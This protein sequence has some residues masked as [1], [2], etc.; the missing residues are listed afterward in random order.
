MRDAENNFLFDCYTTHT[1]IPADSL[2]TRCLTGIQGRNTWSRVLPSRNAL[3]SP[4]RGRRSKGATLLSWVNMRADRSSFRRAAIL[5]QSL[6]CLHA[7]R[8]IT[9]SPA[10]WTEQ[11][12][13]N[14]YRFTSNKANMIFTR[15]RSQRTWYTH[16]HTHTHT[17]RSASSA[18]NIYNQLNIYI[19]K[20]KKY[21]Y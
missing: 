8:M 3:A 7:L 17:Q 4:Q 21:I 15:S 6:H 1:H 10:A 20:K 11:C 12:R 19:R 2:K 16:T 5:A 13:W 9:W 14:W 18:Q